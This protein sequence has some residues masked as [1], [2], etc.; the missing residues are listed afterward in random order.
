MLS[1]SGEACGIYVADFVYV[2]S[3]LTILTVKNP[4]STSHHTGML[5]LCGVFAEHPEAILRELGICSIFLEFKAYFC[6]I[7]LL[8][9]WHLSGRTERS[10]RDHFELN[11]TK[12]RSL[13]PHTCYSCQFPSRPS[14]IKAPYTCRCFSLCLECSPSICLWGTKS[15]SAEVRCHLSRLQAEWIASPDLFP[16][17]SLQCCF[18]YCCGCLFVCLSVF[19]GC[20]SFS[21]RD[22]FLFLGSFSYFSLYPMTWSPSTVPGI[23][24]HSFSLS[25][26]QFLQ[27]A[28]KLMILSSSKVGI[29][30]CLHL[31][32]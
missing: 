17:I 21:D 30:L 14:L 16:H 2:D 5:M 26:L 28:S 24:H 20:E 9:K 7:D 27:Q 29:M 23:S 15:S 25:R 4:S 11:C 31:W 1:Q 18:L 3:C 6:W 22:N 10:T 19:L 13:S 32:Q 12:S 8:T